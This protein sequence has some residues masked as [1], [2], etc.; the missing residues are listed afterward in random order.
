MPEDLVLVERLSRLYSGVL[1]DSLDR[2]DVRD[3]VMAHTLRPLWPEALVVGR[4]LTVLAVEV[5]ARTEPPY[6]GEIAA[7]D[8]LRPGAVLVATTNG[9][10]SAALWGELLST[11]AQARGARGAVVDGFTRDAR[12]IRER[13]F[14][15]FTT[16]VHPADSAGRLDVIAHDVPIRCGGVLVQPG[17]YIFGDFDGVVV[18][19]AD[20]APEVVRLAEEKVRAENHLRDDLRAGMRV[21][22]A[23]AKHGVL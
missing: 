1:A 16:G 20:L 4:A 10:T 13:G 9:A 19:P 15:V 6:A 2:L 3:H 5:Y 8:A 18:I 23:F 12:K 22:D 7:V 11:A 14:P 21:H 17:D